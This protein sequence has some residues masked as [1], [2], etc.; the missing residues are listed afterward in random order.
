MNVISSSALR[1][2]K[3]HVTLNLSSGSSVMLCSVTSCPVTLTYTKACTQTST[4][5]VKPGCILFSKKKLSL[6]KKI[7]TAAYTD[8]SLPLLSFHYVVISCMTELEGVEGI[9]RWKCNQ[10]QL[11]LYKLSMNAIFEQL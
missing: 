4:V 11:T 9:N 7:P 3:T 1:P 10:S 2:V 5:K 8:I 6:I